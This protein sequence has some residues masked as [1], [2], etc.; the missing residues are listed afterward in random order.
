MAVT[1]NASTTAGL[2]QTA[3]TSGVLALQTAGTTAVTV[4][5]SQNVGIGTSSPSYKLS[6][7]GS[8]ATSSNLLLTHNTD[9]TGAYSRIRFQFAEGNASIASEIRNI[10]RVAGA[11]GSNLA[12]FTENTSGTLGEAARIDFSGN[13]GI[14]TSSP[15][16]PLTVQ[17]NS[18]G[19]GISIIGRSTGQNESWLYWYKNGGSVLNAGILGDNQGLKFAIG[20]GATEAA[21]FDTSGNLLV[22]TTTAGYA[23]SNSMALL[24]SS[25]YGIVNHS[26]GTS[27]GSSYMAFGYNASPIGSISQSGTTAVLYNTTS[28]QRLK[29]NIA[30]AD[31]ASSLSDSLQVRKF[32]WKTDQTHQRYG[33]VAQELVTVAPEAVHQP[34]DTEE[35]MAVDYSKLVPMLVKEIQ[36]LRKRL[37]ALESN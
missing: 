35:M 37:A 14:G 32:D 8:S 10:Q 22:G 4:D 31:S 2:V 1:L 27:S 20:S 6:I 24:A 17:G 23:N 36:S 3:D 25:G 30:D 29:E 15:S 5:A 28:D 21:R 18:G 9:S 16:A 13:L 34:T 12:F 26:S 33:F 19:V 7:A 11:S